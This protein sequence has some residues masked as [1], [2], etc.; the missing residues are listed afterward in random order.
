MRRGAC[1]RLAAAPM[2]SSQATLMPWS[3]SS[4][5]VGFANISARDRLR[6]WWPGFRIVP[7]VGSPQGVAAAQ[8]AAARIA[9]ICRSPSA[10]PAR[11]L[12]AD[13]LQALRQQP[14][15]ERGTIA[16]RTGL[17][18]QHRDVGMPVRTRVGDAPVQQPGARFVAAPDPDA[19]REGPLAHHSGLV[20]DLTSLPPRR[21][22]AG[23]GVDQVMAAYLREPPVARPLAAH[24]SAR[25]RRPMPTPNRAASPGPAAAPRRSRPRGSGPA[26]APGRTSPRW[27]QEA[28]SAPPARPKA[29]ASAAACAGSGTPSPPT[30][31]PR[32]R[33]CAIPVAPG[34]SPRSTCLAGTA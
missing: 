2:I 30:A 1:W 9:A 8:S 34:R 6:R 28:D 19:R 4:A 26:T 31:A 25:P 11:P 21:R 32:P 10:G 14:V 7:S 24:R 5:S 18:R 13:A 20:L 29:A 27:P 22:R 17:A 33:P 15:L 16:Q 12:A 23:D 3:F